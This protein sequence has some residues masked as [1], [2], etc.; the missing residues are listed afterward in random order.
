MKCSRW[1]WESLNRCFSITYSR[2]FV[3]SFFRF[4]SMS[5]SSL[6]SVRVVAVWHFYVRSLRFKFMAWL[7]SWVL[8]V[9]RSSRQKVYFF[10]RNK[11]SAL[12]LL[13]WIS[14]YIWRSRALF[15]VECDNATLP[16]VT[17]ENN[18]HS[19]MNALIIISHQIVT[20]S[21]PYRLVHNKHKLFILFISVSRNK[22]VKMFRLCL[23]FFSYFFLFF[24]TLHS[25]WCV[26]GFLFFFFSSF[27]S[28]LILINEFNFHEFYTR[29]KFEIERNWSSSPFERV[30]VAER[31]LI[32]DFLNFTCDVTSDVWNCVWK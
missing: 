1:K 24:F 18:I 13:L 15:F 27:A 23:A 10:F 5:L 20:A 29:Q 3:L 19:H 25:I 22:M 9:R 2:S 17:F 11:N 26:F 32:Y 16:N 21:R 28:L 8:Y 30:N 12:K 14:S 4:L 6:C 7:I 31:H